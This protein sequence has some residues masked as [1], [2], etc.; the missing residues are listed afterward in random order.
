M[1]PTCKDAADSPCAR[2]K[3]LNG[4]G[5]ALAFI[6]QKIHVRG[7]GRVVALVRTTEAAGRGEIVCTVPQNV[8]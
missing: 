2:K 7:S 1:T 4:S 5:S 3:S 6:G 8:A